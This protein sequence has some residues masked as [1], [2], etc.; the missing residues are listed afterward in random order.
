MGYLGTRHCNGQTESKCFRDSDAFQAPASSG[1]GAGV[2]GS[3]SPFGPS[4]I[5][6]FYS[7]ISKLANMESRQRRDQDG[8]DQLGDL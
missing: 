1:R 6:S 5:F 7:L 8:E 4:F 3:I 2:V